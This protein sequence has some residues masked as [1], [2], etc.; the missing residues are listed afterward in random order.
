MCDIFITENFMQNW[1]LKF[2]FL[3]C[4][5]YLLSGSSPNIVITPGPIWI[6]L[7]VCLAAAKAYGVFFY[8]IPRI[9][10][11][12]LFCASLNSFPCTGKQCKTFLTTAVVFFGVVFPSFWHSGVS[13]WLGP[14][15]SGVGQNGDVGLN[16]RI[17]EPFRLE[18]TPEIHKLNPP[19][20]AHCP[21]PSVP[22]PHS[23]GAPP[24]TV[25]PSPPLAGQPHPAAAKAPSE[26][27]AMHMDGSL[28]SDSVVFWADRISRTCL[29]AVK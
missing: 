1:I 8:V 22:H 29:A 13:S 2:N 4:L 27:R 15:G 16:H 25:T 14:L 21:H 24:G 28:L 18:K 19:Q 3:W 6:L 11:L 17:T 20:R 12:N 7:R 9:C 5:N 23:S 10:S 26:L